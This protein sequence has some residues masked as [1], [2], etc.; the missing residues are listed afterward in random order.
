[1]LINIS[2]Y[3]T[4]INLHEFFNFVNYCHFWTIFASKCVFF[5]YWNRTA[6][7]AVICIKYHQLL[8]GLI[9][10]T[11]QLHYK[12]INGTQVTVFSVKRL[13]TDH[14]RAKIAQN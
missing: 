3:E 8:F 10:T 7:Q 4:M 2:L 13:K 9:G 1:V 6:T 5:T 12:L 11:E 14:F